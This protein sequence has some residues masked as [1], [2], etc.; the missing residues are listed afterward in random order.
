M[1]EW[2]Y[3]AVG[4][5]VSVSDVDP[6]NKNLKTLKATYNYDGEGNV[7]TYYQ[8]GNGGLHIH[9]YDRLNRLTAAHR[10]HGSS[11]TALAGCGF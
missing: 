9:S 10:K 2:S 8:R 11:R 6:I 5:A 3:D 4:Q 1:D 7:L